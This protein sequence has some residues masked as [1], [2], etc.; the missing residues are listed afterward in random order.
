MEV[1]GLDVVAELE[2]DVYVTFARVC[3]GSGTLLINI[4]R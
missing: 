1:G 3:S 2:G 4:D